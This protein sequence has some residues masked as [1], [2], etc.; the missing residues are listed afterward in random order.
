MRE[1]VL[2]LA[3]ADGRVTG[4]A[5]TGS[6][7]LGEED[8]WSDLDL[9]F[10]IADGCEPAAVLEQWTARIGD[11]LGALHHFDLHA[12]AAIY[13]VFLLPDCLELD[14]AVAPAAAFGALAPTFRL[15]FGTAGTPPPAPPPA[16][17]VDHLVGLCWHHA[18]HARAAIERKRPWS[19]E[20]WVSALRD[21]TLELACLRLELPAAHARGAD[22][23]PEELGAR[24]AGALVR[25]LE[26]AELHR[27]RAVAVDAFLAEVALQRP[28]LAGALEVLRSG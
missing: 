19:A 14:L 18:L 7:A 5:L 16:A 21:H 23:L 28:L 27:A 8:R 17:A 1:H 13:R 10:G 6:G 9:A 11:E 22:R 25:S 20:Y 26:P 3:R 4:G 15:L 24:L 2:A 12:G